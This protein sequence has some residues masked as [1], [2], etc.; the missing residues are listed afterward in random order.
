MKL[1]SLAELGD[2]YTKVMENKVQVAPTVSEKVAHGEVLLTDA[3]QYLPENA[4]KPGQALGGGPGA[5]KGDTIEPLAKKTGPKGLKG[6]NF[7]EVTKHEDPGSDKK[8]MKKEAEGEE[9]ASENDKQNDTAKVTTPK[10]K[11]E[12]LVAEE[13]KYNYKP[14]FTM[15]KPKFD[16]LYEAALKRAPFT[17]DAEMD[18]AGVPPADDMAADA[19]DTDVDVGMSDDSGEETV[20]IELPKDLAKK[21]H[22]LLMAKLDSAIDDVEGGDDEVIGGEEEVDDV[23]AEEVEAED[24]GHPLHNMKKGKPDNPKGSNQVSDLKV[25]KGA[26]DKGKLRNEPE[27]KDAPDHDKALQNPKGKNTTGTG[28]VVTPGKKMFE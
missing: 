15:S 19:P 16:Q 8:V 4:N 1:T 18:N 11:V 9:E 3:T 17:E 7:E 6:N 2:L 14:K 25:V 13:H 12:D 5:G 27:P 20:T 23:V 28:T 24:E 26:A 21:L 22:E 10:E